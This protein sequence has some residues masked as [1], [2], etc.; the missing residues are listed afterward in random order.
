MAEEFPLDRQLLMEVLNRL[1]IG[2]YVTDRQRR[3]II[4]NRKA[5]EITGHKREDVVGT[6]CWDNILKHVDKHGHQLCTTR[7]CPL[8][9]CMNLGEETADV[10][11]VYAQKADGRRVAVSVSAAPLR[12][13]SGEVVG[14]IET[15]RDET[16][17]VIDMEFAG[18]IQRHLFPRRL[19]ESEAVE[20]DVRYFPH[21]VIG[22][23]FYDVFEVEPGKFSV[24]VADVRGHGVSAALYTMWLKSLESNFAERAGDPSA[25]ISALNR[26]LSR[27]VLPESFATG[28]YG[29]LDSSTGAFTYSNAGHPPPLVYSAASGRVRELESHGMPLGVTSDEVYES[30]VIETEVGDLVF[31]YTDGLTEV[32]GADGK[33]LNGRRLGE[34]IANEMEGPHDDFLDRVYSHVLDL[35][36]EVALA[37]DCMMLSIRRSLIGD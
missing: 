4:W 29:V 9:R 17:R 5:E 1:N 6:A 30:S 37:D 27:F 23:D 3:I 20:F 7:L 34:I 15:F 22:G 32:T 8:Y 36:R 28:L 11:L 25:M 26:M 18:K 24:M 12:D 19:P 16:R 10:A 21:D 35:S 31:L 33:V 2:A 13:E 14:G